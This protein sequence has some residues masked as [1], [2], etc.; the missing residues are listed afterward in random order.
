MT[1]YSHID[2]LLPIKWMWRCAKSIL[3]RRKHVYISPMAM[4]NERT[5]LSPYCVVHRGACVGDSCIGKYTFVEQGS[6]LPNATIGSFCS[7]AK[8]VR[9][10]RYTHPSN[11]FI[12]TSPATYSLAGQCGKCL[13]TKQLF[14]EQ[15]LVEG[16]SAIIGNDVWIGENV[17]IIEGIKIGH[18][19]IIGTGAIVTKDVPDYAVVVGVPAKIIRY[20]YTQDEIDILLRF[21]WWDKDEN[22]I[23]D[24]TEL[25]ANEHLFLSEISNQC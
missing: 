5:I 1:D 25:M 23:R 4:F 18:G 21:K 7:I 13:S 3:L 16:K 20:R 8:N 19:A 17:I 22:W 2:Y 11:G 10:V 9:I 12:S 15:N 6:F 24:N 14:I